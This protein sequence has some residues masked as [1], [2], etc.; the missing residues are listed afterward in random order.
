[1]SDPIP[2]GNPVKG[3][4]KKVG[5]LPLYAYGV[6]IVGAAYGVYWWKNNR[7]GVASPV[8]VTEVGTGMSASGPMPGTN[9]YSGNVMQ[10]AKAAPASVSNAQWAKN[11]ADGMIAT[12]SNPSDAT[13]AISAYLS[14]QSLTRTQQSII[15]VA[16]KVYGNPPEGVIAVKG[17]GIFTGFMQDV[18]DGSLFGIREDG[19]REW[20]DA[21]TWNALGNPQPTSTVQGQYASYAR[22][23]ATGAVY[24]ITGTGARVWL[25]MTQYTALGS[26]AIDTHFNNGELASANPVADAGTK[27]VVKQG[28][29]L[30]S[31]AMANYGSSDTSALDK[32]NPGVTLVPGTVI[33][34]P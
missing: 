6:I 11:V 15:N 13:A 4:G 12:G 26:P 28:D 1:M 17:P 9:D 30:A 31:I 7:V 29:T 33:H 21:S 34:I 19:T 27:Y 10:T 16:L 18:L 3:L 14:G 23:D 8:G 25:T 2:E 32:A 5:P 22:D 24:G 20:L